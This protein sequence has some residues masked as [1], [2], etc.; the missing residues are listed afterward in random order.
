MRY[1]ALYRGSTGEIFNAPLTVHHG[2]WVLDTAFGLR[3]FTYFI[4]DSD[5]P[6]GW[7]EF[8]DLEL[9]AP[10]LRGCD[11]AE[12]VYR[13]RSK[14]RVPT[15]PAEPVVQKTDDQPDAVPKFPRLDGESNLAYLQ[16][17]AREKDAFDKKIRTKVRQTTM[18]F[19]VPDAKRIAQAN[20]AK[21][22]GEE[23]LRVKKP[24][25][26]GGGFEVEKK[27]VTAVQFEKG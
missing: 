19:S 14:V 8:Y 23:S 21:A 17:V 10:Q 2:R 22:I 16:R 12:A 24:R 20:A 9:D 6:S 18:D 27:Q 11:F 13:M 5:S 26:G 3:E 25:G 4:E 15:K 1:K 7:I